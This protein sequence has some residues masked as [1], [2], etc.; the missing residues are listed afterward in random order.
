MTAARR[1]GRKR[2]RTRLRLHRR[3][4]AGASAPAA[5]GSPP[6]AAPLRES[7]WGFPM[8]ASHCGCLRSV[9]EGIAWANEARATYAACDIPAHPDADAVE[10]CF[11]RAHPG[12][13]VAGST[14]ESGTVTTA[15]APADP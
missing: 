12:T 5:P 6:A 15:A 14:D 8:D 11:D 2:E 7:V 9:D 3:P 10:D 13:T 4:D 1:C